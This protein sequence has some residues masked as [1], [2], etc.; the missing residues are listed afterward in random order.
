MHRIW[1]KNNRTGEVRGTNSEREANTLLVV[2]GSNPSN[3][4]RIVGR[5]DETSYAAPKKTKKKE[6]KDE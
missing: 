3:W 2:G 5:K 6:S 4:A 1:L